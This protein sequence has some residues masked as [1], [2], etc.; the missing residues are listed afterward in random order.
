MGQHKKTEKEVAT[1][2]PISDATREKSFG[3]APADI[4]LSKGAEFASFGY[5]IRGAG[6]IWPKGITSVDQK[7]GFPE[8]RDK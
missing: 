3:S 5:K 2:M 1:K 7:S 4:G 6:E 8:N